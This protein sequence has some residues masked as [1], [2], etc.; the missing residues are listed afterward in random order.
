[1][2]KGTLIPPSYSHPLP[3]LKGVCRA[4]LCFP[5][6]SEQNINKV[7]SNK[8]SILSLLIISPTDLSRV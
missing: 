3:F 7:L 8:S 5:P 1:M 2:I 6:L 4:C